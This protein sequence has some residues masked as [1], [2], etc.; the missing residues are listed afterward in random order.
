MRLP[1]FRFTVRRIM[2]A[3][4][5]VCLVMAIVIHRQRFGALK[6]ELVN[7]EIRVQGAYVNYLNAAL[8]HE[9]SKFDA[10]RYLEK[11]GKDW[12][13]VHDEL[14]KDDEPE[15]QT[16]RTLKNANKKALANELTKKEVWEQEWVQ[17][18]RLIRELQDM[19]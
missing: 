16:F 6:I 11:L 19:W 9:N 5:L 3:I 18:R 7:Q 10:T 14:S 12:K 17:L 13:S 4:L 1:R 8:A 2:T 15:D